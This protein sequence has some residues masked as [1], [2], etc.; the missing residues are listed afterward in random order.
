MKKLSPVSII[1][2]MVFYFG[3]IPGIMAQQNNNPPL[4]MQ[5]NQTPLV[6]PPGPGI[7]PAPQGMP[8]LPPGQ[9]GIPVVQTIPTQELMANLQQA[10]LTTQKLNN[11]LSAGKVW[12]INAPAG[13]IEIKGAVLYQGSVVAVLHFN[14]LD[15]NVLPLGIKTSTFQNN[16]DISLIKSNLSSLTGNLKILPAAEFMEPESCWS[17]PMATGNIIVAHIKVYYDGIHVIQDYMASQEMS[18]YGQ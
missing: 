2:I 6:Q 16:V 5:Q 18:F 9:A 8:P 14:P 13:E 12:F 7:P 10:V 17:F 11:L 1:L 3:F 4:L 15:G